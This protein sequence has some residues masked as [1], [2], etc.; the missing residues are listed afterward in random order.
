MAGSTSGEQAAA[1]T[2]VASEA[3]SAEDLER[4]TTLLLEVLD[5]SGYVNPRTASST[6][7]KLRRMIRRM[8]LNAK[9]AELWLGMVRQIRWK[10]NS[11]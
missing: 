6:E 5:T 11:R 2:P 7:A 1:A 4:L 3:A 10:L 8:N 9:D